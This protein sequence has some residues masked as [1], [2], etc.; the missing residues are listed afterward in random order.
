MRVYA[1]VETGGKQVRVREGDVVRVEKLQEASG[2]EVVFDRVLCLAGDGTMI[3]GNP[4][5]PGWRVVGRVEQVQRGR[6]IDVFKY[7]AKVN[8]RRKTGH[9][10]TYCVVRITGILAPGADAAR[11]L[12]AAPSQGGDP[13]HS[14]V[15]SGTVAESAASAPGAGGS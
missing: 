12:D 14:E 9:R 2:E 3:P 11:R 8:Y 6:K 4:T 1:V 10:Q 13:A 15:A 5:V 7:K